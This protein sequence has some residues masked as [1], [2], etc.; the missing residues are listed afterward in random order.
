[1]WRRLDELVAPVASYDAA[2]PRWHTPTLS[3]RLEDLLTVQAQDFPPD[4]APGADG[5]GRD[6]GRPGIGACRLDAGSA[7][8]TLL[9]EAVD[10]DLQA[11]LVVDVALP[12][13]TARD[14]LIWHLADVGMPFPAEGSSSCEVSLIQ[15]RGRPPRATVLSAPP[16][17]RCGTVSRR[18]HRPTQRL[19][20]R[21]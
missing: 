18:G 9:T 8:A 12:S 10:A 5:L 1:M 7:K 21:P 2:C 17:G 11:G 15:V 19:V 6:Q 20:L 16:L 3:E 4:G 13:R 14:A